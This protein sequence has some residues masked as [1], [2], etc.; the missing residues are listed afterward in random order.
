MKILISTIVFLIAVSAFSQD[1]A[2]QKAKKINNIGASEF[3][4]VPD[5]LIEKADNFFDGIINS[6]ISAAYKEF[7][8]YSPVGD[9]TEAVTNLIEETKRSI[10][11]YGK[12]QR[13]EPVSSEMVT[14]S[15]LKL[16]YIALHTKLPM[17][18]LITY[19]NSPEIGWIII[20]VKF[21]DQAEFFFTDE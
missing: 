21:D 9:R 17:R 12:I 15:F 14:P 16:R 11:L 8:R 10:E 5:E 13:V 19:Y 4:G 6:D 3:L 7:L 20:N 1:Q 18:W 2:V